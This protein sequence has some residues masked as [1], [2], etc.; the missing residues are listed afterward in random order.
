MHVMISH[1]KLVSV[2]LDID[3]YLINGGGRIKTEDFFC[4]FMK[5][6]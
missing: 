6:G 5:T 2:L 4:I 1:A 3:N